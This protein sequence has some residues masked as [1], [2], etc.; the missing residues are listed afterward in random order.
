[1]VKSAKG[2]VPVLSTGSFPRTAMLL[3]WV[4]RSAASYRTCVPG[5]A[6]FRPFFAKSSLA[7]SL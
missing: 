5:A 6:V 7:Q 2:A 1:M 4:P 3:R